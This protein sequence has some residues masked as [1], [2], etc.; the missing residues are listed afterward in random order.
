VYAR[1]LKG[2]FC[3]ENPQLLELTNQENEL[4][5]IEAGFPERKIPCRDRDVSIEQ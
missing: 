1:R 4:S 2:S 5:E 3:V